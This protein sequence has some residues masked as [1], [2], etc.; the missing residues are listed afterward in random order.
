M[1]TPLS[2][3]VRK[4]RILPSS[5][6]DFKPRNSCEIACQ[7]QNPTKTQEASPVK[8][9]T[10][11]IN[12]VATKNCAP[13]V[14][15]SGKAPAKS[16]SRRRKEA[17]VNVIQTSFNSPHVDTS[18]SSIKRRPNK[19]S[20]LGQTTDETSAVIVPTP[21]SPMD[22]SLLSVSFR[23]SKVKRMRQTSSALWTL[24]NI[25]DINIEFSDRARI[26][27]APEAQRGCA[28]KQNPRSEQASRSQ[29]IVTCE[30]EQLQIVVKTNGEIFCS[31]S[32][33]IS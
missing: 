15:P 7:K 33:T 19:R 29:S 31:E 8:L 10:M 5:I 25:N 16:F 12:Q 2:P 3:A 11:T 14:T 26:L 18:P 23:L 13:F 6:S 1:P 32:K 24:P 20:H 22:I 28:S 27:F 21:S 17:G 9:D 30:S 4:G